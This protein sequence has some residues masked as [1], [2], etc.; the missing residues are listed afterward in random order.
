MLERIVQP[1][2]ERLDAL[3]SR[4]DA[5]AAVLTR[6]RRISLDAK[7]GAFDSEL[8]KSY[9]LAASYEWL[10]RKRLSGCERSSARASIRMGC[11]PSRFG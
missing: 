11:N 9:E 7:A 10:Q 5:H 6:Q 4:I 3:R 2:V 1:T 8:G